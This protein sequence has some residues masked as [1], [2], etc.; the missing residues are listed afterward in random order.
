MDTINW[1]IK[2]NRCSSKPSQTYIKGQATGQVY[3]PGKDGSEV[4]LW[5]IKD[6]GHTWPGGR[7][8]LKKLGKVSQDISANNL[9]WEFFKRHPLK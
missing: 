9:M 5:T 4:I 3:G 6:G 8:I 7:N 2:N 1:Y